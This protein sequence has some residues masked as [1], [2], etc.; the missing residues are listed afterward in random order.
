[1]NTKPDPADPRNKLKAAELTLER[2]KKDEKVREELH[3]TDEQIAKFIK[4]Q[5][6]LI[7]AL[8]K[9]AEKGDWRS[10]R[11][12]RGGLPGGPTKADFQPTGSGDGSR[13]ARAAP[14]SGYGD[15][16]KKFTTDQSG[17]PKAG[18]PKR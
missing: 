3:W 18:E 7:A 13:G 16:Y 5:E 6:A 17:G 11:S 1:M 2:F 4:D 15:P 9:Q 12:A 14:P 10:D 8:R